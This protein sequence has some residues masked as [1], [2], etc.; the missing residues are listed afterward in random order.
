MTTRPT[1]NAR[2]VRQ[3]LDHH[4]WLILNNL[5][6]PTFSKHQKRTNILVLD[7]IATN[8]W[9]SM[10][11]T[12]RDLEAGSDHTLVSIEIRNQRAITPKSQLR[13][14]NLEKVDKAKWQESYLPKLASSEHD[15]DNIMANDR[16]EDGLEIDVTRWTETVAATMEE[17]VKTK[18]KSD[19]AK[20]WFNAE[21]TALMNVRTQLRM[22]QIKRRRGDKR[23]DCNLHTRMR[24]ATK[25][26][27]KRYRIVKRKWH[28]KAWWVRDCGTPRCGPQEA[29]TIQQ[30]HLLTQPMTS[31]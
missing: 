25:E 16:T 2:N 27:I 6:T 22:E 30:R 1:G 28:Q 10:A 9:V 5:M 8:T 24:K 14:W 3:L 15:F 26:F 12:C 31:L 4:G 23:A 13:K 19:R 21:L 18:Q 17:A 20:P 11:T 29:T 7:L